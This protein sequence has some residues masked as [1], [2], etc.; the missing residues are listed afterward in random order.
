VGVL[1]THVLFNLIEGDVVVGS[2]WLTSTTTYVYVGV[3]VHGPNVE[4]RVLSPPYEIRLRDR[5]GC[6]SILPTMA[7]IVEIS[8]P[9]SNSKIPVQT[10]LFINNE[11]VP[12]VDKLDPIRSAALEIISPF[13]PLTYAL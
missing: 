7:N 9:K 5:G 4:S 3:I 6:S 13:T 2:L 8:V 11:F 1:V 12:S 10:G